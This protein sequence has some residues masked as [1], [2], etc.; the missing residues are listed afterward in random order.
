MINLIKKTLIFFEHLINV[1]CNKTDNIVVILPSS[2]R[3]L[4]WH[5]NDQ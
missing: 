5:N 4:S 2:V 1:A 3:L